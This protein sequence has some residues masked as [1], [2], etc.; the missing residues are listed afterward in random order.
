MT[1]PSAQTT[2]MAPAVPASRARAA[3][4]TCG[5]AHFLHD[6]FS[7]TL[8]VLFPLWAQ[9]FGLSLTQVGMLKTVF[10]GALAGAQIPLGFLAERVGE[11]VLLAAGTVLTGL[12][13][14]FLGLAGGFIALVP[15]LFLSGLGSGAQHPL[16]S[17]LV[18][19][20]YA[21]GPRRAALG[22]Y[23]FTGDLGK[24]AVPWL[25]ALG[26]ATIGWRASATGYGL[27][28]AAGG[29]AVFLLLRRLGLGG[30]PAAPAATK[31]DT[32]EAAKA[33]VPAPGWG[34]HDRRGFA[35]LA[36][37][38]IIDSSTRFGFLTLLPFLLIAKGA[39]V[40]KVGFA[41]ALVFAGGAAGKYLCGQLAERVGIIRTVVLTELVTGGGILVLLAL[42]LTP[43]LALL[44][45]VGLALN[46]TS[47]V[48]YGTV[49]DFVSAE[50][51]ARAFGLFYTLGVGAGAVA[52]LI[53][54]A[55]S[56]LTAVPVALAVVA[57]A[58]LLTL[59][60]CLPLGVSLKAAGAERG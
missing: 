45:L 7:D 43:A 39:P 5:V 1:A 17:S 20:A 42:P 26:A 36:A 4:G 53:Y 21:G 6:G 12:A 32:P 30:A 3:L 34:I 59:P 29:V 19:R 9:E 27:V 15:L 25:V 41:L 35:T 28:G 47:S 55:L 2:T 56:D 11:R 33:D 54:G 10:S 57:A 31:A 58:V 48:L 18:A 44:P 8:F 40:D 23:N 49:A 14:A 46:G 50:R 38:G 13:F 51:Q 52:P 24:V 37:I 16:S 60:L 22:T